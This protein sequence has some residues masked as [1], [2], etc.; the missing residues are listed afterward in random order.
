MD[1]RSTAFLVHD[2]LVDSSAD[3]RLKCSLGSAQLD[4]SVFAN[5]CVIRLVT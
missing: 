3:T 2:D 1:Q 4:I 5:S